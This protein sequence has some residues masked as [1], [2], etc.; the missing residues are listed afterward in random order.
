MDLNI[1]GVEIPRL[2][3]SL[4]AFERFVKSTLSEV[5]MLHWHLP[6][7]VLLLLHTVV[8]RYYTVLFTTIV[9][10]GGV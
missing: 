4:E 7:Y 3:R 10:T 1:E 8:S 9:S 2:G 5:S 6:H